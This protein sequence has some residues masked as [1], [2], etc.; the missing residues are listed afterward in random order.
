MLRR[1]LRQFLFEE[2]DGGPFDES[3]IRTHLA[4][5]RTF[6]AWLRSGVVLLGVGVGTIALGASNEASRALAFTLGG[7]SVVAAVL[8]V[9]WAYVSFSVTNAGIARRR[10]RP[11]RAQA[12]FASLF[13]ILAGTIVLALLLAEILD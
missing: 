3:L 11:A 13:V 12:A 10:Y 5:E 2:E 9:V 6:L 1:I 7:A 8:M 4:N